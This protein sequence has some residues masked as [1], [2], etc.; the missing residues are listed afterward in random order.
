[1]SFL[2]TIQTFVAVIIVCITLWVAF[3]LLKALIAYKSV[4][5]VLLISLVV[6]LVIYDRSHND[7]GISE[8]GSDD[9]QI[10]TNAYNNFYAIDEDLVH[11]DEN[12]NKC[13]N[14]PQYC[15]QMTSC[16]Q[17][18]EAFECGNYELDRDSDGV[19]CES[20]CGGY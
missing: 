11:N 20:I 13:V 5:V 12:I 8:D 6:S 7:Y 2:L 16:D 15:Y 10:Y 4:V 3:H 1:M 9:G 17:A 14:L 19:P 18:I